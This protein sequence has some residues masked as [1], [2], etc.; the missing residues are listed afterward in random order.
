MSYSITAITDDYY[1]GT[2]CL[3]NKMNIQDSEQ[4]AGIEASITLAKT[5]TLERT[6]QSTSFDFE[7]YKNIH[8]YLF[9]DCIKKCCT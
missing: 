2:D 3:V 5:A 9:E 4:L 6:P 7:H 8:R 1:E